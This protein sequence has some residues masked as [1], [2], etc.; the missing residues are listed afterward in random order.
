MHYRF[1]SVFFTRA[2]MDNFRLK[3]E[4]SA[5]ALCSAA[6]LLHAAGGS[7]VR[8]KG[9][10]SFRPVFL[11]QCFKEGLTNRAGAGVNGRLGRWSTTEKPCGDHHG[12]NSIPYGAH[13]DFTDSC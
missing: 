1:G 12:H 10:V 11:Q 13:L 7:T 2:D 8:M 5:I 6:K 9:C 4:A 3:A